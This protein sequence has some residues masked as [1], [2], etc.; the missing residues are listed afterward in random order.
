MTDTASDAR[1]VRG[2]SLGPILLSSL[3]GEDMA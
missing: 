3:L 1:G 2:W